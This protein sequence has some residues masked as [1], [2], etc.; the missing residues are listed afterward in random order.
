MDDKLTFRPFLISTLLLIVGGWG[1][2]ALLVNFSLPTLWPRWGLFALIVLAGTGTTLPISYWLNKIFSLNSPPKA[3]VIVRESISVGVYFA[4]LTWLG[5]GRV[6]NFPIAVWLAI[7]LVV[8]EY[9]LRMRESSTKTE[10][11]TP[12]PPIN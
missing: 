11:V 5:I 6:L 1:G 4:L 7:G 2:L 8:V 10:N 9:L 12:Q 3:G